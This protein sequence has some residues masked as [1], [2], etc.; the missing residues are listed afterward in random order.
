M[1]MNPTPFE[2]SKHNSKI[3]L[4]CT[5]SDAILDPVDENLVAS[6]SNSSRGFL[7]ND[8]NCDEEFLVQ[9]N[10]LHYLINKAV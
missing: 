2:G 1:M 5:S 9:E 8:E 6:D 4:S 7:S 3:V 10:N